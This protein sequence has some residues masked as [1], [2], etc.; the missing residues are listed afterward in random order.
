MMSSGVAR[1]LRTAASPGAG[2]YASA[3]QHFQHEN[4]VDRDE[5]ARD[6]DECGAD[7]LPER[8]HDR[9]RPASD[10]DR[11]DEQG[12]S[13]HIHCELAVEQDQEPCPGHDQHAADDSGDEL[14][15]RVSGP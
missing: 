6:G 8:E 10:R 5:R 1:S 4:P 14:R 15:S 11:S 9:S 2:L 12:A 7:A 13:Q 3:W